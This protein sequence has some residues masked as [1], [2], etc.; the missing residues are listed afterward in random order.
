MYVLGGQWPA[1]D[2][3]DWSIWSKSGPFGVQKGDKKYLQLLL[4]GVKS[5]KKIKYLQLLQ[6][7]GT[8]YVLSGQWP[9]SDNMGGVEGDK[10]QI[11]GTTIG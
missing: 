11:S 7:G 9:A 4:G 5:N 8:M 3:I 6:G 10:T 1:S 2:I